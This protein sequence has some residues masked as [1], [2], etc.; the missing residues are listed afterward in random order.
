MFRKWP[1]YQRL[2]SWTKPTRPWSGAPAST[3]GT[4][5]TAS[6]P[7]IRKPG[8]RSRPR[9]TARSWSP[10]ARRCNADWP[11]SPTRGGVSVRY[12]CRWE[13]TKRDENGF[14]LTTS[15][16]EYR[17]A[18]VVFALGVTEPWKS[19]IPG[20]RRCPTT[21]RRG[22]PGST[23]ARASSSSGSATP[24]SSSPTGLEPW[25]RQIFLVSPRPVQTKRRR[26]RYRPRALLRA[27]RGRELGRRHV[28]PR[29][30]R[31]ADR[32]DGQ[33]VP[34]HGRRDDPARRDRPRDGHGHRRHGVPRRL[35]AT[36]PTSACHGRR[37]THPRP[38]AVLG[39]HGLPGVL[40]REHHAG[41][42]RASG[43]TGSGA[44]PGR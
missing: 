37:R 43:S 7:T 4:T 1:I 5:T 34:H 41:R 12:D 2:L 36:S 9:W 31:G 15:D 21:P 42:G 3:S 27:L 6:S 40:R 29:R 17:C 32:G 19:P 25:A 24:A 16:G 28:R 39:K 11:R 18:V 13:S 8:T 10:R 20:S 33:R 44:P 35:S 38:D 23:R 22:Q 30:G 14:T 26:T